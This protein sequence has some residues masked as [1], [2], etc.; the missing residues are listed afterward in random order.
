MFL[1]KSYAIE[2]FD[3]KCMHLHSLIRRAREYNVAVVTKSLYGLCKRYFSDMFSFSK[4]WAFITYGNAAL[5][6]YLVIVRLHLCA[7]KLAKSQVK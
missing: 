1:G 5:I 6:V 2:E 3:C 7:K 4:A